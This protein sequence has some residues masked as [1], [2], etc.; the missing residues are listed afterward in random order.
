MPLLI[1]SSD[2]KYCQGT[3]RPYRIPT[4]WLWFF[5]R[6]QVQASQLF[7]KRY[8]LRQ[9]YLWNP[10][11]RIRQAWQLIVGPDP[12]GILLLRCQPREL[13]IQYTSWVARSCPCKIKMCSREPWFMCN[14][15]VCFGESF[16][17]QSQHQSL[18][19]FSDQR[20]SHLLLQMTSTHTG[21]L[22]FSHA[23]CDVELLMVHL[24]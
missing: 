20:F 18:C 21:P 24:E 14:Q 23:C 15:Q 13:L 6:I 10:S 22:H 11:A 19:L 8:H 9:R 17:L 4:C 16:L 3:K 2:L 5:H 12:V 1:S 7:G